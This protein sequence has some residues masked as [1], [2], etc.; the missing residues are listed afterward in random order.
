MI[1]QRQIVVNTLGNQI[2]TEDP[3]FT[4]YAIAK[5]DI[6]IAKRS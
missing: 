1:Q 6:T 2:D 3:A 5:H 4:K